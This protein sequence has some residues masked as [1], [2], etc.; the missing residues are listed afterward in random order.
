LKNNSKPNTQTNTQTN[1]QPITQTNTQ[2]NTQFG[3]Q[4]NTQF[5]TQSNMSSLTGHLKSSSSALDALTK[6]LD[7]E[8]TTRNNNSTPNVKLPNKQIEKLTKLTKLTSGTNGKKITNKITNKISKNMP[9]NKK[10]VPQKVLE[11]T[12][13]LQVQQVQQAPQAPNNKIT[14]PNTNTKPKKII[15]S[16]FSADNLHEIKLNELDKEIKKLEQALKT[17]T[18]TKNPS[19]Q[20]NINPDLTTDIHENEK[21]DSNIVV[22]ETDFNESKKALVKLLL[23][24][25]KNRKSSDVSSDKIE[26]SV[27]LD[28]KIDDVYNLTSITPHDSLT[29]CENNKNSYDLDSSSPQNPNF[30]EENFEIDG[31]D[32]NYANEE[33]IMDIEFKDPESIK[34]IQIIDDE[35]NNYVVPSNVKIRSTNPNNSFAISRNNVGDVVKKSMDFEINPSS[36]TSFDCYNDYMADLPNLINVTDLKI[37][38]ISIPK[39]SGENI[40]KLNN[41]L[42]IVIDNREQIFE[43]EENYYNRYEIKDFLNE[44]FEAYN[45]D[46]KCELKDDNFIFSSNGKFAMI[47]HETSILPT[48][49]FNRNAYVNR[50]IYSAEN[51]HQIGDNIFYL[52]IENISEYPLFCINNDSGEIN[53]LQSI[54]PSEID[55]L[56]IKFYKTQKDLIKNNKD[57][58]FFFENS[59]FIALELIS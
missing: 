11:K 59:H 29:E 41:E 20:H 21:I 35:D 17:K 52:V 1:T 10:N 34:L 31:Y 14:N 48:L 40:N 23:E 53:K 15:N 12:K 5:G 54:V 6:Q 18:K 3:T 25:K 16:D 9:A 2:P 7:Y 36:I 19:I 39:N 33:K 30:Y 26:P 13:A 45:F 58:K 50:N 38:N 27:K 43:L 46:I 44:A 32:K 37:K 42:K 55:H 4:P 57:Y 24:A 56:I 47:N 51:C 8:A 49:G 28:Q 22:E